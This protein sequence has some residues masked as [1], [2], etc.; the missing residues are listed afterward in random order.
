MKKLLAIFLLIIYA[1]TALGGIIVNFHYCKGQLAHVSL[2]NFGGKAGC[3]CN[4]DSMPKDCCKDKT[5]YKKSDN[6]KTVQ[7]SSTI[8][9]ISSFTPDLP[10]VNVLHSLALHGCGYGSDNFT[11]DV[12][13]SCPQPIYL[14]IRVF[15]I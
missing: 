2:L 15:R 11:N 10:P 1:S 4:P 8:N 9:T 5:L 6:H 14:L 3:S 13:R 12:N 7:E